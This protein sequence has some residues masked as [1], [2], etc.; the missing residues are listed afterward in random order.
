MVPP[1][2]EARRDDACVPTL[3]GHMV[4]KGNAGVDHCRRMVLGSPAP[5]GQSGVGDV[6]LKAGK[7]T[8]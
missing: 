8:C 2:A 7:P 1:E 3:P 6:A 4:A 5:P